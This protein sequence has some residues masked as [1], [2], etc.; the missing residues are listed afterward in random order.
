MRLRPTFWNRGRRGTQSRP[1]GRGQ[2]GPEFDWIEMARIDG[3]TADRPIRE[4]ARRRSLMSRPANG[5]AVSSPTLR[6]TACRPEPFHHRARTVC[7]VVGRKPVNP[8]VRHRRKSPTMRSPIRWLSWPSRSPA[9][10]AHSSPSGTNRLRTRPHQPQRLIGHEM[11]VL[12]A[13]AP[14]RPHRAAEIQRRLEQPKIDPLRRPD[15]QSVIHDAFGF[16]QAPA[17]RGATISAVVWIFREPWTWTVG[18][19]H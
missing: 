15:T 4:I 1:V 12:M 16:F 11:L 5:T 17:D 13:N 8:P 7:A 14:A 18:L 2:V 9:P 10:A 19:Q 6:S 3:P